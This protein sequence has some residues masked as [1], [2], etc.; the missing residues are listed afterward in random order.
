MATTAVIEVKI[1]E[2]IK[3]KATELLSN[4]GLTLSD[5]VCSVLSKIVKERKLP[6]EA[7]APNKLT[8]KTLAKSA[9]N[10][11]VH[12]AKDAEH[13]FRKLGI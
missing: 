5:F 9:R 8:A 1:A 4:E 7:E 11:G 3:S 10:K 6:F 2:G 12:Q 13:L